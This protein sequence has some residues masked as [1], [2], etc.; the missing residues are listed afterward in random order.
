MTTRE[1]YVEWEYRH[2]ERIGILCG[3]ENPTPEQ[4]EIAKQEADQ[5]KAIY[6]GTMDTSHQG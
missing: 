3:A 4:V 6:D 5:W 1:L 2:S